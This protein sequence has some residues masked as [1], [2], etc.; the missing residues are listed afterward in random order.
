MHIGKRTLGIVAAAAVIGGTALG[1]AVTGGA[2]HGQATGSVSLTGVTLGGTAGGGYYPVLS[3]SVTCPTG[4]NVNVYTT[5][6]QGV[7]YTGNYGATGPAC[8]GNPQTVT[9]QAFSTL[10]TVVTPTETA[11]EP[12]VITAGPAYVSATMTV[13]NLY[14]WSATAALAQTA[15]IG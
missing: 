13:G 10:A 9:I 15:T 7:T 4:Y 11:S 8:T 12:K 6:T 5:V 2:A 14:G 3:F 1:V